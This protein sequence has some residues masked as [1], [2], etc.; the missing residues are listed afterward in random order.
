[1]KVNYSTKSGTT[2]TSQIWHP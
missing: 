1:M 2:R